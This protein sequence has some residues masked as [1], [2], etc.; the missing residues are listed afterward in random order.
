M[1]A[2]DTLELTY[3]DGQPAI[4]LHSWEQVEAELR[5]LHRETPPDYPICVVV[6]IPGYEIILGLGTDPTFVM[7]NVEPFDGEL[8]TLLGDP[9]AADWTDYYG[10]GRHT[11]FPNNSLIPF[12]EALT[13]TRE[14]VCEQQR[15]ARIRWQDWSGKPIRSPHS[16]APSPYLS[17]HSIRRNFLL[18]LFARCLTHPRHPDTIRRLTNTVPLRS[19]RVP[20]ETAS[21]TV[22]SKPSTASSLARSAFGQDHSA[23]EHCVCRATAVDLQ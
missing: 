4:A 6:S 2:P 16:Q 12:E 23:D 21:I 22:A 9:E 19:G 8:Y 15:C 13:A 14:F 5:Q 3:Q 18:N 7:V 10:I 17:S 20:D 1:P 11:P